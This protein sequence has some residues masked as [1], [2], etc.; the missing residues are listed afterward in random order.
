MSPDI[1]S[2]FIQSLIATIVED[3][4]IR[5]SSFQIYLIRHFHSTISNKEKEKKCFPFLS[6]LFG[7]YIYLI[8]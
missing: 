3:G 7:R 2:E 8:R 4:K 6:S 1:D 5:H